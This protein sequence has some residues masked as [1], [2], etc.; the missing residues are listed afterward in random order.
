[1]GGDGEGLDLLRVRL[2]VPG[3]LDAV[4]I[5]NFYVGSYRKPC[6]RTDKIDRGGRQGR[7]R[8]IK[9]SLKP[10]YTI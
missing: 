4:P 7:G 3:R 6:P 10:T 5:I 1:M 9:G 8:Y 2:S